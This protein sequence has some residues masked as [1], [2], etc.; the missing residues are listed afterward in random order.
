MRGFV[1]FQAL[2]LAW[3]VMVELVEAL[4]ARRASRITGIKES[5][6]NDLVNYRWFCCPF[7]VVFPPYL[8]VVW[9]GDA[10]GF[11]DGLGSFGFETVG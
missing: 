10:V 11:I 3:V 4:R 8:V 5:R 9:S 7:P 6:T 2:L 1:H